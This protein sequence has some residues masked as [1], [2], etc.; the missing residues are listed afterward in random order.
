M[1]DELREELYLYNFLRQL[2][3]KEPT[4]DLVNEIAKIDPPEETDDEIN[5]G[6]KLLI[7]SSQNNKHRIDAWLEDLAIEYA[8]LFIGPKNPPVIPYASFYLSESHSLMTDETIDVRKRYLEAGLAVKELYSIPDDHIGIE[9]EFIYYL[10]Q[11]IIEH[12]EE[13]N[14][15]DASRLFEIRSNFLNEHMA[16]WV[17]FFVDRI[18]V[19]TQED[20]YRGAAFIL[21]GII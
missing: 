6:L 16:Q 18:L 12:F 7:E 4:K 5:Y 20:F 10:T 15:E 9:L 8:R 11:K 3:L 21:R 14:R 17:P 13:G 2:F 1:I 19:S